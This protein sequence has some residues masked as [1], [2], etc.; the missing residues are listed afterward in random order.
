MPR[1]KAP[2]RALLLFCRRA[3]NGSVTRRALH[4]TI[5]VRMPPLRARLLQ[6][7]PTMP[8][9]CLQN[10]ITFIISVGDIYMRT[11]LPLDTAMPPR[12]RCCRYSRRFSRDAAESRAALSVAV[13]C[14]SRML[15]STIYTILYGILLPDMYS[16]ESREV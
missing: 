4:S 5:H 9:F 1:G 12:L 2:P 6:R 11:P 3:F 10:L 7:A 14:Q 8:F 15:M 13:Y 16:G